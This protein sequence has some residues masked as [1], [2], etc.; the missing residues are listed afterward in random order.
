MRIGVDVGG[1]NTDAALM[2]GDAV[3]ATTKT[4]TT[5]DV[6]SGVVSA[7]SAVLAEK[8][9]SPASIDVVM[10]GTTHFTNAM[11]ERRGL[12]RVAV[13]RLCLPA[14][15]SLPPMIDWPADIAE[16]IG[17]DVYLAKG[18]YEFDG[19]KINDLDPD[20][21]RG[22]VA[23]I[24]RKGVPNIAISS[25]F[26]P[27]NA[28]M[29]Q[30][31]A[32]IVREVYP[33]ARVTL[34]Y[35]IGRV[36]L[37]ERE[38]ATIINAALADLAVDVV[39]AFRNALRELRISAPLYISQNDGTLMSAEMVERY[40]V[41][42]FASG[43]T[44]SMRGAAFLS[45]A[46]DAIVVD[47]G[48][49]T[50]DVGVLVGGF[51]RQASSRVE[52]GG[53]RTNFRM[54]DVLSIGVGGG[55]LISDKDGVKVGPKSVGYRLTEEA[56]VFGGKTLTASDIV[57]AAGAV[58]MGDPSLVRDLDPSLV[59]AARA[60]INQKVNEAIDRVKTSAAKAPVILVG[61]GAVLVTGDLPA[62][63]EV[64]R[65]EHSS[66]ANAIGAAIAQV[67]GEID[68]VYDFNALGREAALDIAR[69]EAR[70]RAIE[71]GADPSTIA[72]VH[73]EEIPLAYLP[74]AVRVNVKAV[75]D[76][77]AT[78]AQRMKGAAAE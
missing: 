3:V 18:G 73:V 47:I 56:L 13:I 69:G 1:T 54:P 25:V 72:I 48:G 51:P 26:A 64:I 44:N 6:S 74:G 27:L 39:E 22:I 60:L 53:V 31:A 20:E 36:G 61:G 12:A 43:P 76:L 50:T 28:E 42:T 62:A 9:Q 78:K 49:T 29:E 66:V 40:P 23:D 10:I 38:N 24:K 58:E 30:R 15:R 34:S 35:E 52:I 2:D 37:L 41:L 63:S 19:R 68:K 59:E 45:K 11:V 57:V 46:K 65:P 4:A 75:G 8:G 7:I 14:T 77:L 21:L 33:E 17:S 67:G 70:D 16:I 32:E 71:A 55:S 5:R